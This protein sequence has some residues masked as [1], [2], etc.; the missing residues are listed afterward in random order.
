M[1][2]LLPFMILSVLCFSCIK[3]R[4][5]H[6]QVPVLRSG[7]VANIEAECGELAK[8][9]NI[10]NVL[11]SIE[12]G[13]NK[14]IAMVED[15][16]DETDQGPLEEIGEKLNK[17]SDALIELSKP[18][19]NVNNLKYLIEWKLNESVFEPKI[20]HVFFKGESRPE[21]MD[22]ISIAQKGKE[23]VIKYKTL[24]T[25]L[26]YCQLSETLMIVLEVKYKSF[27]EV[28]TMFYNLH[29]KK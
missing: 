3:N 1:K 12:K 24:G 8:T 7:G 14:I 27:G 19:W 29:M 20:S 4:G 28:K 10:L 5:Y 6:R 11:S 9:G 25:L 23:I 2:N 13:N 18:E 21:F 15:G 22:Y 16:I 26:E 17:D